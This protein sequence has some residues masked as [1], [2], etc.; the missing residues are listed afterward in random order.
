MKN[1]FKILFA[2]ILTA[3][4]IFACV[5]CQPDSNIGNEGSNSGNQPADGLED[6]E[7]SY[8][9]RFVYSYTAK[10]E[11][12]SG[13]LENKQSI[14]TVKSF[15]IPKDNNGISAEILEEINNLSY[16]GFSFSGWYT[17]WDL[18]KQQG[19]AGS[20]F[21]FNNEPITSDITLYCDRG[22]L[23]GENITWELEYVYSTNE[24]DPEAEPEVSDVILKL[25]G[26]GEMFDFTGANE[27]DV[28]WFKQASEITKVEVSDGITSIGNN[29]F[30]SLSSATE[31]TL[32]DS[33]VRIGV[34]AFE[35]YGATKFV[36]PASLKVICDNAFRDTSLRD[37]V[38][39]EG[40]E[41]LGER[42]F[43]G[44]N[45]IKTIVFPSTVKSISV[46]T[47]HP[48]AINGKN[49][50]HSLS[51][52]YYLGDADSF[53]SIDVGI[54]NTW[55]KDKATIY[56]YRENLA[57]DEVGTYWHYAENTT[58]AVQYFYTLRYIQGSAKTF[59]CNIYVRVDPVLD[60]EGNVIIDEE[61]L[62]VLKGVITEDHIRQQNAITYHNYQ[63]S[64]F[65]GAD[66][67]RV[68]NEIT[69]D[70]VYTCQRGNILS[71]DGGIKWSF[72]SDKLTIYVDTETETRIANDVNSRIK[73]NKLVLTDAEKLILGT[74]EDEIVVTDEIKAKIIE[75]RLENSLRMW[76][77]VESYDATSI[78][79]SA[80]K[81]IVIEEGI[82]YIG[83][84]AFSGISRVS[85]VIIPSSVEGIN[86]DAFSGCADLISVFYDG[87]A[88]ES[89]AALSNSRY[90]L[91]SK[92]EGST[93]DVGS[94][95]L[96]VQKN[97]VQKKL[98]WTL[99]SD[100][101]LTIG[102]D[103]KMLNF[104]DASD[105]PWYPAKD[106]V[107][108]VAF[109]SNIT[110]IAAYCVNG[111]AN[112]VSLSLPQNARKIPATA[113]AGTG[114]VKNTDG[115]TNGLLVING[116][117]I[118]ANPFKIDSNLVETF[119]GVV[120]IAEGAFDGCGVI[121][122]LY[123]ARTVQYIDSD[124]FKN[125]TV[126]AIFAD[127][128]AEFWSVIDAGVD[129]PDAKVYYKHL[130]EYITITD[131]NGKTITVKTSS[132]DDTYWFKS[133]SEYV[134][135]GCRHIYGEYTEDN[136]ATCIANGTKTAMCGVCGYEDVVEIPDSKVP[137]VFDD[138][139]HVCTTDGCKEVDPEY[140]AE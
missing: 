132:I 10:V 87:V 29:A 60:A 33:I 102:G 51:K 127:G 103:A 65:T 42:A 134:I 74:D 25:N 104:D 86:P 39:N 72:S 123:V 7:N 133:G 96:Y 109:A 118:K 137:H 2:L 18:E 97:G 84:Y 136:N 114:I 95:W 117:L 9:I 88:S 24:E 45:K 31:V 14:I 47:F 22:N 77:F 40:L 35:G 94:Y 120:T 43:Y 38:L 78:W 49:N 19:V 101:S 67:L 36:A 135:W 13:R 124:A 140:S 129:F 20:E 139:T 58:T 85:E 37:V 34:S 32:P 126:K 46:G 89:I 66:T 131:E 79:N 1:L 28:P 119:T 50:K 125:C 15:F 108:S 83:K 62:P 70:L 100:G 111:Y 138:E 110:D 26:S 57:E 113:F 105:A 11:N 92:V 91:Y 23:A 21:S 54:D 73:D 48:G 3:A 80:T 69:A 75:G 115:Y 4:C 5:S 27:V 59:L 61:G 44:S 17:N 112:V 64:G 41:T 128:N 121:N 52:V 30:N 55:F 98:A 6:E 107:V 90:T 53:A 8:R 122:A 56:Y 68:G 71:P 63:F 82:K 106:S 99:T 12:S 81:N 93:S 116:H 16:H 130:E 76:D